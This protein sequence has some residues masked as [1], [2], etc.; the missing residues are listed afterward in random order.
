MEKIQQEKLFVLNKKTLT[1]GLLV[2]VVAYLG[3][4]VFA[5]IFFLTILF[6]KYQFFLLAADLSHQDFVDILKEIEP[7]IF[8]QATTILILGVDETDNRPGFPQ[9]TDSI[10]LTQVDPSQNSITL[11]SLPRDLWSA[12]YQTKI[13][14]LLEYGKIR[15]PKQPT[16]FP[17]EVIEETTNTNI[18]YS[19]IISLNQLAKII[20]LVGG[21]ELDVQEGFID[22]MYPRDDIDITIETDP[23]KL[24]ETVEFEPGLQIMDGETALKYIRSRHSLDP[25][26]GNDLARSQRQ[27][28]VIQALIKSLSEPKKYWHHPVLAGYLFQFY[29]LNFHQY[30]PLEELLSIAFNFASNIDALTL[31]PLSLSVYPD[32]NEGLIEHPKNLA[33]YQN[34]WVYIIRDEAALKKFV[35]QNFK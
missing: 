22:E 14:A 23:E 27:Q 26:A 21:V 3:A 25:N 7:K 24:F 34:Q 9:L 16:Q 2:G 11:L 10:L 31:T 13:N 28:Q 32:E 12:P 6:Q 35:Q 20:D 18:N 30:L 33:P 29:Q 4:I 17:Q 5:V 19:L 1:K 15:Y 8:S